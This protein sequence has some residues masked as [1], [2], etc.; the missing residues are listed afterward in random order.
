VNSY[1]EQ[2]I[3][4]LL[5]PNRLYAFQQFAHN[6]Y[7]GAPPKQYLGSH[8][9]KGIKKKKKLEKTGVLANRALSVKLYNLGTVR[10]QLYPLSP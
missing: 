7:G 3:D 1:K 2:E 8:K 4:I 5:T 6:D 9:L 10:L